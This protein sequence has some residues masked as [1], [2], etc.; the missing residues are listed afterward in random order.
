MEYLDVVA[1][2]LFVISEEEE[3]RLIV[4]EYRLDVSLIEQNHQREGRTRNPADQV[5]GGHLSIVDNG[6]LLEFTEEDKAWERSETKGLGTDLIIQVIE[7]ESVC[8]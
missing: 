6:R 2:V 8:N 5:L 4:L 1:L 7:A 3:S